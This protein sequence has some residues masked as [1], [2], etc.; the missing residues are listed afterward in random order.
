MKAQFDEG[1]RRSVPLINGLFTAQNLCPEPLTTLTP[2]R[3]SNAL[4]ACS[5]A[6]LFNR[7]ELLHKNGSFK[8]ARGNVAFLPCFTSY[9]CKQFALAPAVEPSISSYSWQSAPTKYLIS[10]VY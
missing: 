4:T 7:I 8:V 3:A 5:V 6:F 10:F 2:T 9:S 1:S